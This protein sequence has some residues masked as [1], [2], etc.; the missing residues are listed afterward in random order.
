MI[1]QPTSDEPKIMSC[2]LTCAQSSSGVH[3]TSCNAKN[4][5]QSLIQSNQVLSI[6][7]INISCYHSQNSYCMFQFFVRQHIRTTRTF[8]A[9][10]TSDSIGKQKELLATGKQLDGSQITFMPRSFK[11]CRS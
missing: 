4:K 5:L 10:R 1:L 7:L 9:G 2:T 6:F 8:L 3:S 11:S